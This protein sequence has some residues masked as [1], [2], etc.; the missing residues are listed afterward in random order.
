MAFTNQAR[1]D[2]ILEIQGEGGDKTGGKKERFT[3]EVRF[4]SSFK[5]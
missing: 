3:A 1:S 2:H 4:F 5:G